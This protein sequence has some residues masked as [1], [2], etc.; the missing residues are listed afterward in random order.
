MLA[1]ISVSSMSAP[2]VT[3]VDAALNQDHARVKDLLVEQVTAPVRWTES[4]EAI[5]AAG[6]TP[7]RAR[8]RQG[9]DGTR[10]AH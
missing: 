2:V 3:N 7:T 6:G 1:S 5:A 8:P 4:V 9:F 10:T